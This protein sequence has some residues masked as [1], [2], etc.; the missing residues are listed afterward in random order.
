MRRRI[1]D[2][3]AKHRSRQGVRTEGYRVEQG[4]GGHRGEQGSAEPGVAKEASGGG[5][6]A[7]RQLL[8]RERR[9]G[10]KCASEARSKQRRLKNTSVHGHDSYLGSSLGE[11]RS[12]QGTRLPSYRRA[13][14]KGSPEAWPRQGA[15]ECVRDSRLQ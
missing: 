11:K 13:C 14:K 8:R 12:L 9:G 6:Q 4:R 5:Q 1:G 15:D 2:V 3:S 10:Q 7:A